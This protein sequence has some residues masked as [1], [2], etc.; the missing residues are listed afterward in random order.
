MTTTKSG[1]DEGLAHLRRRLHPLN[2]LRPVSNA[3]SL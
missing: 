3:L 2:W 1:Q